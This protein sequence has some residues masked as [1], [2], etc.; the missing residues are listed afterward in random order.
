MSLFVYSSFFGCSFSAVWPRKGGQE[1][2]KIIGKKK[3][4]ENKKKKGSLKLVLPSNIGILIY[5]FIWVL[6]AFL[7]IIKLC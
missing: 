6:P 1:I 4:K 2:E 7:W 3:K 5:Y